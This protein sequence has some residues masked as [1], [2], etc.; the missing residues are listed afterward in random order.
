D[1]LRGADLVV[2]GEGAFD[3]QSLYGKAPA[4]ILREAGD[5]GVPAI[6]LCGRAEVATEG[7]QVF[8][9]VERF[10]EEYAMTRGRELLT[11]LASEVASRFEPDQAGGRAT[12]PK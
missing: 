12:A 4:G 9:L 7:A 11:E 6:I 10:G 3:A 5:L 2:T 8:S 1:R